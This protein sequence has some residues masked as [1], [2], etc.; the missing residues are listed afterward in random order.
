MNLNPLPGRSQKLTG[1][2]FSRN[3]P[4]GSGGFPSVLMG[5]SVRRGEHVK[6]KAI[7]PTLGKIPGHDGIETTTPTIQY[8][9]R[10][11]YNKSEVG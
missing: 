7:R 6:I 2:E 4:T 9:F 3:S 5:D 11:G 1:K 10:L 8:A